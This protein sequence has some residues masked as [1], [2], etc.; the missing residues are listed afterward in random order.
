MSL[1]AIVLLKKI[2]SIASDYFHFGHLTVD[3][4]LGDS[5]QYTV[6]KTSYE[7]KHL[8]VT[9]WMDSN[10]NPWWNRNDT[11]TFDQKMDAKKYWTGAVTWKD[12]GYDTDSENK[13]FKPT[14]IDG[15]REK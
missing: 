14:I 4:K 6:D 10:I 9:N 5:V 11:A 2:E 1:L 13:Q 15:G 7:N 8:E 3:S 12:L